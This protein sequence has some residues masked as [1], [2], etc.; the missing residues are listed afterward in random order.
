VNN[1]SHQ[2]QVELVK[3][4][5]NNYG[6]WVA[7]A[8]LIGLLVGFGW[9]WHNNHEQK[10]KMSASVLYNDLLQRS[11]GS[12][13]EEA[14]DKMLV[15]QFQRDFPSSSYRMLVDMYLAQQDIKTGA[16]QEAEK[17]LRTAVHS[18]A[19]PAWV[20]LAK[21]RLARV[22]L[23]QSKAKE[24]LQTL[25]AP[26]KNASDFMLI[27]FKL[28]KSKAYFA[29]GEKIKAQ[30]LVDSVQAEANSLGIDL[31]AWVFG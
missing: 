4:F 3:N 19:N 15:Q 14:V 8:L 6:R 11:L 10:Q 5:W 16:L 26:S 12:G 21:V 13:N 9:R 23:A 7:I 30:Q 24:A 31:P 28:E 1:L 18:G 17:V 25:S 27:L 20:D 29:L 2:E 22:F